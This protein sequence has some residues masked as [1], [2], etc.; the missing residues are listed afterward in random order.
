M[1]HSFYSK[2]NQIGLNMLR[3]DDFIV[4]KSQSNNRQDRL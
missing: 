4:A 2:K 3:L 1:L